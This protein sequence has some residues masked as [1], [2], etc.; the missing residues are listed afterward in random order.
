MQDTANPTSRRIRTLWSNQPGVEG[1]VGLH[2][3]QLV[4]DGCRRGGHRLSR[5]Y[6]GATP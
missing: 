3:A 6:F 1:G 2:A 4:R 5:R